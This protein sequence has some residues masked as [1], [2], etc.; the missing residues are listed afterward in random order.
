MLTRVEPLRVGSPGSVRVSARTSF[1]TPRALAIALRAGHAIDDAEFDRLVAGS[2]RIPGACL[3]A[4][5]IAI[6]RRALE[7]LTEGKPL[8]VLDAGAGIGKLCIVG[9]LTTEAVFTG[10]ES[11]LPLVRAARAAALR[12]GARRITFIHGSVAYM[13]L[14][15]F[16]AIYLFDPQRPFTATAANRLGDATSDPTDCGSCT[17]LTWCNLPNARHGTRIVTYCGQVVPQ[18]C[19][20]LRRERV[21]V[22][23]LALFVKR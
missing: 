9:A 4:T 18:G 22:G 10:I 3:E 21:G 2:A 11:R 1:V 7:L 14:A 16:D 8:R 20:V 6:A 12:F 17:M 5:P 19:D 15:A 13:E 23:E